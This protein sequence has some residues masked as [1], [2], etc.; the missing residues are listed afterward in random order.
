MTGIK[1]ARAAL[2]LSILSFWG[3]SFGAAGATSESS[4]ANFIR[5]QLRKDGWTPDR[6][7]RL[8]VAEVPL[9]DGRAEILAYVNGPKVCGDQGCRLYVLQT[10]RDTFAL[11]GRFDS[12]LLPISVLSSHHH[13]HP[14]LG[15]VVKEPFQPTDYAATLIFDGASYPDSSTKATR[16]IPKGSGSAVISAY[17]GLRLY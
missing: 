8:R 5:I 16:R 14:D 15:V 2:A 17:G 4:V 1:I 9:H 11:I 3:A 10:Q 6:T 12:T 13:G 7:T